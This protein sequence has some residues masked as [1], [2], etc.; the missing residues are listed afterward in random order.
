[1]FSCIQTEPGDQ[2]SLKM[3]EEELIHGCIKEDKASQYAL[4]KQYAGKMLAVCMRYSRSRME[5]EDIL[6]EGFVKVFDNISRFRGNGSFEGWIR[7]IMVNT[8]LKLYR[9][10]CFK[11]EQ[12][13]IDDGYD[14][15]EDAMVVDRMSEKELLR[16][17][18]T[19]PDGYKIVFNL[20]AIEGFSHAEIA[21]TLHVNE[22]TSRSQLAK[23]RKWLQKQV[24]VSQQV[25][26]ERK[27]T[28]D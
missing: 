2:T 6:Q 13:G 15:P 11:N 7:R 1:M 14:K 10:N 25:A 12:V 23:A 4:Y 19:L 17:V 26:Y 28:S 5:A 27:Q 24:T 21:E 8:A 9:K 22:G 3:T 16:M 18:E 20:Y